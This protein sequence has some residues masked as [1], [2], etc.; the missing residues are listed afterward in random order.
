VS[1]PGWEHNVPAVGI[2][3]KLGLK[4]ADAPAGQQDAFIAE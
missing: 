2:N 4:Q 3:T 1:F